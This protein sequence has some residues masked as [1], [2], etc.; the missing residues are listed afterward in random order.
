MC[1]W[2]LILIQ[3]WGCIENCSREK[4]LPLV[5]NAQSGE[6]VSW[7]Q[8][9]KQFVT[10]FVCSICFRHSNRNQN[11]FKMSEI[12]ANSDLNGNTFNNNNEVVVNNNYQLKFPFSIK[13]VDPIINQ[14][15]LTDFTGNCDQSLALQIQSVNSRAQ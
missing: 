14:R 8:N 1:Y 15:L 6:R 4:L 9:I 3:L 13:S 5:S 7:L 10:D 12:I 11:L 2:F